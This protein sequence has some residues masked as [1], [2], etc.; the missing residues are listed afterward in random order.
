MLMAA[1]AT[2]SH[3]D[4]SEASGVPALRPSGFFVA[5]VKSV[6]SVPKLIDRYSANGRSGCHEDF[7]ITDSTDATDLTDTATAFHG[8]ARRYTAGTRPIALLLGTAAPKKPAVS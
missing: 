5:F 8:G 6:K 7:W 2:T 4:A 1:S 3:P